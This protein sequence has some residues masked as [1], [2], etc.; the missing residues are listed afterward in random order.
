LEPLYVILSY[1]RLLAFASETQF[2]SSTKL[3][4]GGLACARTD[5]LSVRKWYK[6]SDSKKN[7]S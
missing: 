2:L 3:Q 1:L 7:I 4:F 6:V 5:I